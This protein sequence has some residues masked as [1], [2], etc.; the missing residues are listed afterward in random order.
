MKQFQ[1]DYMND[2]QL[3]SELRRIKLWSKGIVSSGMF[4]RV[5]SE[6]MNED[7]IR[8]V[9]GIIH[10]EIPDAKI[11]G[12]T[13]D[14][15]IICGELAGS[16]ISV[17]CT[18]FEFPTTRAEILMLPMGDEEC[19]ATA[20]KVKEY[21]AANPW[22]KAV[23]LLVTINGKSM[24][25]FC[26]KLS[27]LPE[28][29]YVYGG[30]AFNTDF[31]QER[32]YV[33]I[34]NGEV[35]ESAAVFLFIGGNNLNIYTS[36]VTGWKP[37][38]RTL[39][40]TRADGTRLYELD[41]KP[42]YETYYT[43]LKIKNDEHF[44]NNTLGFPF[45]MEQNGINILRAPVNGHDDGSLTM[46]ADIINGSRAR[47]AYG[48]PE[49]ILKDV[50]EGIKN[51]CP[52]GPDIIQLF[53]CGSRRTFWG[54]GCNKETEDF[55]LVAPTSGFYTAGEFLRTGKYVN[56]HNVTLVISAL[57]EGDISPMEVPRD[58]FNDEVLSGQVSVV[59]RLANFVQAAVEELE[60]ANKKLEI[61]AITD[62]LTGLYNRHEIQER[63]TETIDGKDMSTSLIMIDIDFF[64]QVND[65]FGHKEGDNVLRKLSALLLKAQRE[66]PGS[67]AGRWGGEEFMLL[68]PGKTKEEAFEIA[69]KLRN[70]FKNIAFPVSGTHTISA[71]VTERGKKERADSTAQRVDKALYKAKES[72]RDRSIYL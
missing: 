33:F 43:Y 4:F 67:S 52:F 39:N 68:L 63:L 24:T 20:E 56:L 10:L 3:F 18:I 46:T 22:V 16:E 40:V 5:Y 50:R 21:V 34:G 55:Q 11:F 65:T 31:D 8:R 66:I 42:A 23:E 19:V 2:I 71:G 41:G 12:A 61:M 49:K 26:N 47:I 62:G 58:V 15:N 6:T 53:S 38:G 30:A 7:S 13:T 59:S 25:E 51:L 37:L 36:F 29:I 1:F 9:C 60:E 32:A 14:G 44:F 54:A 28:D 69:E 35:N 72:G 27:E 17:I 64:K 45:Y 70:E 57:H 48:D